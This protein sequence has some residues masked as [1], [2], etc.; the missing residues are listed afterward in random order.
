MRPLT[1][2]QPWD[3]SRDA[4]HPDPARGRTGIRPPGGIAPRPRGEKRSWTFFPRGL[5]PFWKKV[6]D[7]FCLRYGTFFHHPGVSAVFPLHS[8]TF[9]GQYR[10][11][12]RSGV[13]RIPGR[14]SDFSRP[15]GVMRLRLRSGL[16]GRKRAEAEERAEERA[17]ERAEERTEER[18]EELAETVAGRRTSPHPSDKIPAKRPRL[19]TSP[20]TP[21]SVA[22]ATPPA[23]SV[24]A[25]AS[26]HPHPAGVYRRLLYRVPPRTPC[27]YGI[28]VPKGTSFSHEPRATLSKETK[29]GSTVLGKKR[30]PY[31]LV[32]EY[33]TQ[34]KK[35]TVLQS[36]R[37]RYSLNSIPILRIH[38]LFQLRIISPNTTEPYGMQRERNWVGR[39]DFSATDNQKQRKTR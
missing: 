32:V 20:N 34:S 36:K 30:V 28:F 23:L 8:P 31:L 15:G 33:R 6:R 16:V 39:G 13:K 26:S 18:A 5:G 35:S 37:V 1:G 12:S 3:G 27:T 38:A 29:K 7:L 2:S 22:K 4:K 24:A 9:S 25:R 19:S 14:E 11:Q 21:T 17:D 10:H